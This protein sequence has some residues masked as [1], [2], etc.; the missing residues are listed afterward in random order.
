[1]SYLEELEE[2]S[3]VATKSEDFNY[4]Q[5]MIM[6]EIIES[7]IADEKSS[8][9]YFVRFF[10]D[11]LNQ[12]INFDFKSVLSEDS[13]NSASEDAHAC[14]NIFS[15]FSEMRKNSS[16]LP[17]II[18]ALKYTD[19]LV[20]HYIQEILKEDPIKHDD[21][22]IERSRYIQI[23]KSKYTAH[24]AGQVLNNLYEQRNKLEHR[25]LKDPMNVRKQ[26]ILNPDYSKARKKIQND[27]PKAL[28][29]FRKAYIEHY[30]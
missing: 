10:E 24:V 28:V 8:D 9:D 4:G 3:K 2:L 22:G 19:Q 12:E 6:L 23:N 11:I 20:L 15:K 7:K 29:S 5:R 30:N 18:T 14:I 17:W 26:I 21:H 13:Y 25:T 1:M 27:Y 16:I